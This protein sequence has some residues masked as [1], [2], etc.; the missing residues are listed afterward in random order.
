[1]EHL[2]TE[3]VKFE[4]VLS[5]LFPKSFFSYVLLVEILMPAEIF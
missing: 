5:K 4:S 3:G 1:M 2:H